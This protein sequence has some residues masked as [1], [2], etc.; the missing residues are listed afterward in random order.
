MKAR[1]TTSKLLTL[2]VG[3]LFVM[4]CL[5]PGM[6]P[7]GSD[8]SSNTSSMPVMEKDAD[9]LLETLKGQDWTP[10]Q[11][12]ASEQYDESFK[13]VT[14]TFTVKITDDKPTYFSYGWCTTTQDILT[15]NFEHI[16]IGFYFNDKLID[17]NVIHPITYTRP[18]GLACLE[19]GVMMS[20]WVNGI[21]N[22]KSVATFEQK[23][24]DGLSD[25]EPGDYIYEYT[26]TVGK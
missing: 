22:L 9:A 25:Y 5:L 18:D 11:A 23:I 7:L 3:V 26:I 17:K 15:Q 8:Q 16:K 14:R 21:Y 1:A 2:G 4:S 6:I 13:P 12:L 10:L 20:E 19:F 24:N